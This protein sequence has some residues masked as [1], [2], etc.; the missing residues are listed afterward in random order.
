MTRV[1]LPSPAG[2]GALV[3]WPTG[4]AAAWDAGRLRFIERET[5][6]VSS[7]CQLERRPR[8]DNESGGWSIPFK[9]L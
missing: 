8:Q 3:P 2:R 6:R 9:G 7:Y 1:W 4:K 5:G